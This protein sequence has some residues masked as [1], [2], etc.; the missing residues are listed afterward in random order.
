MWVF[1]V[2]AG[3][4]VLLPPHHSAPGCCFEIFCFVDVPLAYYPF[5]FFRELT[6][7]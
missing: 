1:F 6:W 3:D 2:G 7:R 4:V 5:R